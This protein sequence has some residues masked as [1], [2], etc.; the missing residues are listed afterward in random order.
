MKGWPGRNR[1]QGQQEQENGFALSPK[2]LS[3]SLQ[4]PKSSQPTQRSKIEDVT[5]DT[6]EDQTRQKEDEELSLKLKIKVEHCL[7]EIR[8]KQFIFNFL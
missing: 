8:A 4:P 1:A 6:I 7:G 2:T 3:P 5:E